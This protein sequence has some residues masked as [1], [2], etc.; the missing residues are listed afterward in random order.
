[1]LRKNPDIPMNSLPL[2]DRRNGRRFRSL[3]RM[4]P[5]HF[6]GLCR[7][8]ENRPIFWNNS[9]N[10]VGKSVGAVVVFTISSTIS[11]SLANWF[12]KVECEL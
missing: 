4:M 5:E 7:L 11:N 12:L 6:N 3:F 10:P 1:M 8:I 9:R 2:Y